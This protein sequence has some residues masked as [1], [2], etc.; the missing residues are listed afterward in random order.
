[1]D[2]EGALIMYETLQETLAI[3]RK[4]Y[5]NPLL[6]TDEDLDALD[7]NMKMI[8]SYYAELKGRTR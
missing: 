1:M 6:I 4:L 7:Y 8:N 3:S 2:K 5:E